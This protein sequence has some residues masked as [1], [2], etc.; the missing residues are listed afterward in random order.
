MTQTHRI[1]TSEPRQ[2]HLMSDADIAHHLTCAVPV[3]RWTNYGTIA[4]A[5]GVV[6][7]GRN[8]N[9]WRVAMLLLPMGPAPWHRL[10]NQGGVFNVP[11]SER[12]DHHVV[13][14]ELD[15]RLRGEGCRVDAAT[16][17][18]DARQFIGAAELLELV[19]PPTRASL[20]PERAAAIRQRAA[21][22][23]ARLNR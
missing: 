13:R 16:H 22:R 9:G 20:D 14:Q 23:A 18:A 4:E 2:Y 5:I 6:A 19:A 7:P 3:G 21:E 8:L 12:R 17:A 15:D 10:R 11:S 1:P